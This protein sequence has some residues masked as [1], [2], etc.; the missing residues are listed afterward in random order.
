MVWPEGACPTNEQEAKFEYMNAVLEA[1]MEA[2]A[3]HYGLDVRGDFKVLE[4]RIEEVVEVTIEYK[5]VT[6]TLKGILDVIRIGKSKQKIWDHKS[7]G[8]LNAA[9]TEAWKFRFQFMF[10]VWLAWNSPTFRKERP[11]FFMVNGVKKTLLRQKQTETLA[12]F[13]NRVTNDILARPSEYLWREEME[14]DEGSIERF[15]KEHLFPKLDRIVQLMTA[16]KAMEHLA[17]NKNTDACWNYNK[18]CA[19]LPIC[20]NNF[21]AEKDRYTQRVEKHTNYNTIDSE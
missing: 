15:E 1:T 14:F 9:L 4:E 19:F 21:E 5:G 2:Y 18:P 6:I 20:S 12:A 11:A 17:I 13:T 16:P 8:V 7:M 10:Y 3:Q